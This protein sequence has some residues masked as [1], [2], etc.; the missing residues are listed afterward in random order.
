MTESKRREARAADEAAAWHTRLGSKSVTPQTIED[1][2]VWRRDPL[3]DA[4]YRKVEGMW[5]R[6]H[7]LKDSPV[8]ARAL[9]DARGRRRRRASL[10]PLLAGAGLAA[11]VIVGTVGAWTWLQG[12]EHFTTAIGEER[13][14]QLADGSAVHL[15][16]DSSVRVRFNGGERRVDL[17]T[18]RALFTVA[19]EAA[20]PF[21]VRS[22]EAEVRAVGT[23]FDV[24]R[25]ESAVIVSMVDGLVEVSGGATGPGAPQRLAAGQQMVVAQGARR[26]RPIDAATET[27][28]TR[29]RLVFR[30]APLGEAVGEVNRYL[31]DKI[32]L[33][34][35]APQ[36]ASV[37]GVFHTGDREA[38]VSAV[39][40]LLS[41]KATRQPNGTVLLGADKKT[42]EGSAEKAT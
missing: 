1:F 21:I 24:R 41:L 37:S 4:A 11:A 23:I 29:N 2:F 13:V 8:I 33:A 12:R 39:G 36:T 15:D 3:N 30:S 42:S 9:E 7:D 32:V 34:P 14:I 38:F 10:G 6:A 26:L 19:H 25:R 22:G 5:S 27:S 16:T 40:L 35:D 17:E 28:W 18:G 20:R 31:T